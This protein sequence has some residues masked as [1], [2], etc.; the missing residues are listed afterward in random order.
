MKLVSLGQ[1]QLIQLMLLTCIRS[2]F[3]N[4]PCVSDHSFSP[5]TLMCVLA[6]VF[7]TWLVSAPLLTS[8]VSVPPF[9]RRKT[10]TKTERANDVNSCYEFF[11][12]ISPTGRAIQFD[13]HIK[14]GKCILSTIMILISLTLRCTVTGT[15]D[16]LHLYMLPYTHR[17]WRDPVPLSSPEALSAPLQP[18]IV[19]MN[20]N[21]LNIYVFCLNYNNSPGGLGYP[22]RGDNVF[23]LT[24]NRPT[25]YGNSLESQ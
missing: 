2:T 16:Y 8:T 18:V 12:S 22:N 20:T 9:N 15:I 6:G 5:V 25:S 11:H 10:A 24:A 21:Q 4:G 13:L 19:R 23:T 17:V 3:L 7:G 14:R 1:L